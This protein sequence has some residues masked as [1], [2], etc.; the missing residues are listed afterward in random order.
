MDYMMAGRVI[1]HSVD[2]GNDPVGES[3]CGLTVRPEDP[4]AVANGIRSLL[5]M[6]EDGR[7]RMGERGQAYIMANHTYPLLAQ[8]FLEIVK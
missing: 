3:A 7:K 6:S 8:R 1:L 2:A 4:Q 5:A